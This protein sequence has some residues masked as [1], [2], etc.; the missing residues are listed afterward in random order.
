MTTPTAK[1]LLNQAD[2]LIRGR[3]VPDDL[4]VLTELITDDT[5]KTP[6]QH[7][8]DLRE[9]AALVDAPSADALASGVAR[10]EPSM[11]ASL[12]QRPVASAGSGI[13]P[14]T[15]R[16]ESETGATYSRE[17][18]D[19]AIAAKLDQMGHSV[20]SQVMQQLELHATG[21]MKQKLR[22]ALEP[23]LM[24]VSRDIA[25]QVAEETSNQVQSIVANAV[26]LEVAR[27][28]EQILSKRRDPKT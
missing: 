1:D 17:Q 25:A 20:Y 2:Q 18:F 15:R 22:E 24:Q 19:A 5:R 12:Q 26:E 16:G 3:R 23:A 7:V 8:G 10:R 13:N 9:S 28:R 6:P 11:G 27:L 14:D 4:P 21:E